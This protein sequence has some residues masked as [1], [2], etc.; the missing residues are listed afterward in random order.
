MDRAHILVVDDD[1]GIST[2]LADILMEEGYRVSVASTGREALALARR[3]PFDIAFVDIRLPD[4]EGDE[5][6]KELREKHPGTACIIITGYASLQ[7]AICALDKGAMGYFR[8][9]LVMAEV[10]HRVREI[11]ERQRLDREL[12]ASEE[13]YRMLFNSAN[14]CVFVYP[15]GADGAPGHFIE[16]N[17]AACTRLGYPREEIRGLS[18]ADIE[19]P[20]TGGA[21]V[22]AR[23]AKDRHVIF[24]TAYRTKYGGILPAE[25]SSHLFELNGRP[26]V[27]SLAR[28]ITERK[29]AEELA[30]E[31]ARSEVYGFLV[32]ALPVFAA[33]V[34]SHVRDILVR[35]FSERFEK[36]VRPRYNEDVE[37]MKNSP[38]TNIALKK[39]TYPLLTSYVLWLADLFSSIGAQA[40]TSTRG[41]DGYLRILSCPWIREAQGNPVFCLICRAMVTRS[42][43]WT[44]LDGKARQR[45][46][47]A[48]GGD[49]CL[50]E[51]S[52]I[53]IP[54]GKDSHRRKEV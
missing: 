12:V 26:T 5:V 27:L 6:L 41:A 11:A 10:L 44:Y 14:D 9:P 29:R 33:S 39:A 15:I 8:K 18:P 31:K 47:I 7:N 2:T 40:C 19:C 36:N 1:E 17:D 52:L 20:G 13:R 38:Y 54:S 34:P 45:S 30:K 51:F 22:A 4:M 53:D 35:S 23:L 21:A 16:V 49:Q 24:E 25:V 3:D 50:F 48:N 43:T 37:R 46:S 28:D 42:F 32:S